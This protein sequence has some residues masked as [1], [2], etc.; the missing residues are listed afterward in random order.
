MCFS[1]STNGRP[2]NHR[3]DKQV[4]TEN[5]FDSSDN[6]R[7]VSTGRLELESEAEEHDEL[8]KGLLLSG[9]NQV[10]IVWN[11]TFLIEL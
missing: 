6:H 10:S 11:V 8:V 4:Q 1:L 3:T 5:T 9:W 7:Q 2:S